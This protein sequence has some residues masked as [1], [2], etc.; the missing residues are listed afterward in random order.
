VSLYEYRALNPAGKMLVGTMEAGTR[1]EVI[2][3]LERAGYT[4]IAA[5]ETVRRQERGWR[6][7][8][9]PEPRSEDITQFTLDLAM[10]LKGGVT[11]D[12]ALLILAQMESRRWL[13]RL[14]RTL[15][16]ELSGGKSFSQVLAM[17][18]KLFPPIYVKMI[19]V[20]ETAGRL[21]EALTGIARERTR[22]EALRRRFFSAI[23][24]PL[25]LVVAAS[26]VLVF[27]LAYI[28]PQF[29]AAIAGFR[30][31]LDP[32][33]LRVFEL[34]RA[35][36]E[37][38]D[39]IGAAV[40]AVLVVFIVLGR[41]GRGRSIWITLM[42]RL[43]VTRA[44]VSYDLTLTFCRTLAILVQN[45]VDISTALRLIRGVVR[46][47][48]AGDEIDKVIGDVRQGRRLSDSLAKR[49]LLPGHVVQMLRVG[50]E[51]GHL[52][53]SADRIGGFYEAKLDTALGRVTAIIGPAMMIGVSLLV[54]WLIISVMTA[55]ISI[56]DLLV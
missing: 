26:G 8:L 1:A 3:H 31:K 28:I 55:L 37:N 44:V 18:P 5:K 7:L 33:A 10:L 47:P 51:S 35:F 29:E 41:L 36:R 13:A 45:G 43:P 4:P 22:V 12:E 16:V 15:H 30:S 14:I 50:E 27:V 56:N 25:F 23:S 46:L 2:D 39:L 42:A 52:A 53:D 48:S 19:E 20:A 49:A 6:E 24:Y 54:A 34:S 21:E 40:I 9:T 17:H 38:L 32:S 11:L